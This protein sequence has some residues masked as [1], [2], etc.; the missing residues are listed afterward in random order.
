[1]MPA[2]FAT[3]GL[4]K[5]KVIL[6]KGYDTIISVHEVTSNILSHENYFADVVMF[7][8]CS[9]SIKKVITSSSIL[10]KFDQ[11][12]QLFEGWSWFKFN[13]LELILAMALKFYNSM[14]KRFKLK[15]ENF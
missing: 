15:F 3:P 8:K 1:M 2:K 7:D 11:K 4:L 14:T 13:N 9:M 12:K 10:Q 5:V 6:N